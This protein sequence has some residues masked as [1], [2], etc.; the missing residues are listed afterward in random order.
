MENKY[1][2]INKTQDVKIIHRVEGQEVAHDVVRAIFYFLI[3]CSFAKVS[4]AEAFRDIADEMEPENN[5][6]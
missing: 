5:D 2:F 4:I 3:G 1:V 6:N